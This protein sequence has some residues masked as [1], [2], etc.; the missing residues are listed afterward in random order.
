MARW[1]NWSALSGA[2]NLSKLLRKQNVSLFQIL[3][4]LIFKL[5]DLLGTTLE[6]NAGRVARA[7]CDHELGGLDKLLVCCIVILDIVG[8][9]SALLILSS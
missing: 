7:V 5:L 4:T 9:Q 2:F 3:L 1:N 8:E 6:Q